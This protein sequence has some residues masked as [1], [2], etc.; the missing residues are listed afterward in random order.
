[1]NL[2]WHNLSDPVHLN[3]L[4]E[5]MPAMPMQQHPTYGKV[6]SELGR[7]VRVARW[8]DGGAPIAAAQVVSRPGLALISRGPLWAGPP[9]PDAA[10]YLR[11]MALGGHLTFATPDH[12]TAGRGLIPVLTARHQAIWH[13]PGDTAALRAGLGQK[14]RNKLSRGERMGARLAISASATADAGWLYAAEGAQRRARSYRA[15]PPAFAEAWRA[16]DAGAFRLYAARLD[17]RAVAGILILLHRPWASYHLAWSDAEG[18]RLNAHR[19]LLWR[20]AC[21]LQD[22]GYSALDLGDVNTEDAPGLASFKIGTGAEI[23]ALGETLL[24]LPAIRR[25]W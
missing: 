2:S 10:E 18:R 8:S 6:L 14:W 9:R 17:G 22:D 12:R 15:L 5:V 1:M 7:T 4:A 21:D 16:A 24:V 20:A 13:L 25:R 23:R 19:L 3:L 11:R